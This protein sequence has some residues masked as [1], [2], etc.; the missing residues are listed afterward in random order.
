VSVNDALRA[1]LPLPSPGDAHLTIQ[2]GL[3]PPPG[4][5]AFDENDDPDTRAK[6][7]QDLEG[8]WGVVLSV[9]ATVNNLRQTL[10]GL[11]GELQ[12]ALQKSLTVE[13]KV[14]ARN[15]DVAHWNKEK[16]RAHFA[17]P[18]V[19]EFIHRATW[20]L[21]TPER[22]ALAAYFKEEDEKPDM[23]LGE[24]NRLADQVESLLKDRQVLFANGT[25]V[26][27]ECKSI[28]ADIQSALRTLHSNAAA[29]K[30]RKRRATAAKSKFF[31]DVRKWSGAD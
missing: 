24:M 10:E 9:E 11:Q 4:A 15:M 22:K 26:F 2:V 20:A 23:A 12:N 5:V 1:P 25:K 29:N 27:Q 21:S 16:S 3:K 13:E 28:S 18:K 8:R 7:W 14:H 19:R 30:E 31:K 17:L 6:K